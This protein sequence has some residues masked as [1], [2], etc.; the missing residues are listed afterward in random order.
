MYI[1]LHKFW[2]IENNLRVVAE[3]RA[4]VELGN[5]RVCGNRENSNARNEE[6]IIQLILRGRA[7]RKVRRDASSQLYLRT[8]RYRL[9][10]TLS[11]GRLLSL[12]CL[13]H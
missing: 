5:K 7:D 9:F 13:R 3:M 8:A 6:G 4:G 10:P 2:G 12:V 11:H 1:T